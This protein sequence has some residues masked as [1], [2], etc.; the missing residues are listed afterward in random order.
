M[1]R[2]RLI[3]AKD[4]SGVSGIGHVA[5]GVM[6]TDEA[7]VIRWRGARPSTVVWPSIEDV[8]AVHGH[9]G[10]TWIEWVD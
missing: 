5:D 2:F 6:F 3:R 9:D 7:V 4:I 1:R 8:E 10:S